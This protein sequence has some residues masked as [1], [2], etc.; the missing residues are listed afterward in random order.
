MNWQIQ[1]PPTNITLTSRRSG[2]ATSCHSDFVLCATD[3]SQTLK[4]QHRR[5]THRRRPAYQELPIPV[6][7]WPALC[8]GFRR[9]V[10][11]FFILPSTI[12]GTFTT[13]ISETLGK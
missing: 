5:V 9:Q 4:A 1:T 2:E 10:E 3:I 13:V 12:A 8:W 6:N 7:R 11:D